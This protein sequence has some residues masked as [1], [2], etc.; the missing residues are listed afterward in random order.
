MIPEKRFG[1][2]GEARGGQ[3]RKILQKNWQV[4]GQAATKLLVTRPNFPEIM[5]KRSAPGTDDK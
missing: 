2:Y 3:K 1:P 4:A 5:I